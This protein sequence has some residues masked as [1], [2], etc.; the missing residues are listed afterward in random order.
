MI[1]TINDFFLL[2]DSF[3][4]SAA[5]F[6]YFLIGSGL[7]F[8]FYLKFP[9]LRYF[10]RGYKILVG[11]KSDKAA[12]GETTPFQ[13][14]SMVLSGTVGTGNIAGVALAIFLGGPA[15]LFWMW[16]T[17]FVGMSTKLVE[18]TMSHKYREVTSNGS[19]AGGPMYYMD[20]RLN[21]K[22]V[23]ILFAI[24]VV[25]C[26]FGTGSLPQVNTIA[27]ALESSFGLDRMLSGGILAVLLGAV[28]I[29]GISRIAYFA[30]RIMPAMAILYLI[31]AFGVMIFNYDN[32]I[33][34]FFNI[35]ADVFTGS[36]ATGGFLGA[37]IAYA[38]NRGVSRGLYSNEAGQGSAPITLSSSQTKE[39][40][41][42]GLVSL[43]SPFIDTLVICTITGLVILS[44]GV[45]SEKHQN[46]FHSSDFFIVNEVFVQED[47]TDRERLFNYINKKQ[48]PQPVQL[49]NGELRVND[50]V[51]DL[52]AVTILHSRSIA[53]DVRFSISKSGKLIS[54]T[55]VVTDGKI[56]FNKYQVKGKS[57]L[58]SVNLTALAFTKSIFGDYGRYFV[59][60]SI[61]LFAF[62]TA[63]AWS[64]IGDRAIIY[65]FGERGVTPYRI[66]YV[67]AFFLAAFQDTTLIWNFSL[68]TIV[69]MTIPNL[70]SLIYNYKEVRT[71]VA[72]YIAR[73]PK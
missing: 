34:S 27:V 10:K 38:F 25:F 15:A 24:S 2:L 18:V 19:I 37:S 31:G 12:K 8:T 1:N 41:E 64:Y 59:T 56:D 44:S 71:T 73:T 29:G 43:M 62:S 45:W 26:S 63:I 13:A 52:S 35:F 3:L 16:V 9:Q 23:A 53:E 28:I 70:I 51:A 11:N 72:E 21:W 58:H 47:P 65:L 57:L 33:P 14:L 55:V 68:I 49:F 48:Q 4:G 22:P 30:S 54:G 66:L 6:P 39:P 20:K 50:G 69:I 17:A 32:I 60:I 61:L 40:V 36:A 7:F 5:W 42:A 46:T 67:L